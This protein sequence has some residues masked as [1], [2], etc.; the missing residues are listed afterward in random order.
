MGQSEGSCS[1]QRS[2]HSEGN[3]E[4][5]LSSRERRDLAKMRRDSH[6]RMCLDVARYLETVGWRAIVTGKVS[7]RGFERPGLG[8]YEFVLERRRE[9]RRDSSERRALK[10]VDRSAMPS[11]D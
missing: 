2:S 6:G 4:A 5:A 9:S 1:R 7:I 8:R 10:E 3:D 11:P